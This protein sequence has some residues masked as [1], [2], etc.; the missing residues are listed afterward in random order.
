MELE[1][2][3]EERAF[4]DEVRDFIAGHLPPD[5]AQRVEHDLH[6]ERDDY[7]RWQQILGRRGWHA[8]T[9]PESQG[10]PGW[11]VIQRYLFETISG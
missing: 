10:G 3:P 8:Y 9:W 6:L 4:A 7:M 5:I 2:T 11:S 1:F